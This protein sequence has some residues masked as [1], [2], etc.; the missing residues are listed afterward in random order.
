MA[1][2]AFLRLGDADKSYFSEL[3]LPGYYS[4]LKIRSRNSD[5]IVVNLALLAQAEQAS[6][7]FFLVLAQA[8]Q[9]EMPIQFPH[10]FRA[11]PPIRNH[12]HE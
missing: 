3:N 7:R 8:F 11:L 10:F 5:E 1:A 4:T 2:R 12:F 9:L 6:L